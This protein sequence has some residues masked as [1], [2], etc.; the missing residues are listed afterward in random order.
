MAHSDLSQPRKRRSGGAA[1]ARERQQRLRERGEALTVVLT[2]PLAIA[3]LQRLL[4]AG[5]SRREAVEQALR[6]L[7]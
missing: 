1:T 6:Q 5:L 3:A 7:G 2:D 4:A